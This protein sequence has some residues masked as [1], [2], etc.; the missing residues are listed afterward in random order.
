MPV[1]RRKHE[2][3][4]NDIVVIT[5]QAYTC[6]SLPPIGDDIYGVAC[7]LKPPLERTGAGDAFSSAFTAAIALG[8]SVEEALRWGPANSMS[9]VQQVGARA[10]LLKREELEK[11]LKEAPPE[12]VQK[13]I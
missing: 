13:E 12:Y 10:G 4:D 6:E 1:H 2:I 5:V 8:Q 3:E 7:D 9:V 11:L